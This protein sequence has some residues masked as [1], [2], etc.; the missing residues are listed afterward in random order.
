M[1]RFTGP[2]LWLC[3]DVDGARVDDLVE[4]VAAVASAVPAA[5]WLRSSLAT[6]A[7]TVFDVATRLAAVSHARGAQLWIG[8]RA[9]IAIAAH[10]DGIH[11]GSR[12]LS[13]R[14][15]TRLLERCENDASPRFVSAAVHDAASASA[16][17]RDADVFILSPLCAVPG[18]APALGAAGFA[19][20]V[21][22]APAAFFV[23]LG[24]ISTEDDARL[25]A[26]AGASAI[27]VRRVLL[28]SPDPVG[29]C[30]A[31]HDAFIAALDT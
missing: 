7:R 18:K 23:A 10:A 27:A 9:D 15:V 1:G 30:V 5:I 16:A 2:R 3:A 14:A 31:L 24:G 19:H 11:V 20:V 28:G 29:P 8:D 13:P 12:G 4:R 21:A 22:H 26:R 17:A 6:P 25:A